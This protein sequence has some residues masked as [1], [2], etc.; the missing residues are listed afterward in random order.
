MS[1]FETGRTGM[2]CIT[3]FHVKHAVEGIRENAVLKCISMACSPS[4]THAIHNYPPI[5]YNTA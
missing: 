3:Y 4:L 2:T 1:S 5:T